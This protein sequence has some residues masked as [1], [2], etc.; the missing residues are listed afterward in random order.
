MTTSVQAGLLL[1]LNSRSLP[2]SALAKDTF[3]GTDATALT[4]HTMDIGPGWQALEGTSYTIQSNQ[5]SAPAAQANS[6]VV[7]VGTPN[8]T[9]QADWKPSS[10]NVVSADAQWVLTRVKDS[11][12]WIG[13]VL[14]SG[15][16]SNR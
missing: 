14:N 13:V 6:V 9:V 12:N 11:S 3:T 10:A 1:D 7:D 2:L 4:S 16:G 5:A 8:V 15:A